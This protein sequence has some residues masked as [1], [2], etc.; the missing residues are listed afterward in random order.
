MN[1]VTS[2]NIKEKLI[3]KGLESFIKGSYSEATNHFEE[4][5]S[6]TPNDSDTLHHLAGCQIQLR[7]YE[8]AQQSIEKALNINPKNPLAWFRLGQIH[9]SCKRF[10]LAVDSFG[11]AIELKP[12]FSDSWF[13]GGQA[14]IQNGDINDGMLALKNALLMNPTSPI[15][16]EV[17]GR[18][19]I[20]SKKDIGTLVVAGNLQEI[21]PCIPFLLENKSLNIKVALITDCKEAEQLFKTISIPVYQ[22]IVCNDQSEVIKIKNQISK[23]REHYCCPKIWL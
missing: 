11:K 15:F 3:S 2:P 23:S 13:M 9:Y 19:F 8:A 14:L 5:L 10:V 6:N 7:Q 20:E 21:I 1:I 22:I 4:I 12:D 16:N 18:Q 17:F